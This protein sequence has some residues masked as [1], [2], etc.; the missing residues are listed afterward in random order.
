[1]RRTVYKLGQVSYNTIIM[2]LKQIR[3]NKEIKLYEIIMTQD[4]STEVYK[5]YR[6][7][8]NLKEAKAYMYTY[9]MELV[10]TREIDTKSCYVPSEILEQAKEELVERTLSEI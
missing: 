4:L 5:V 3:R 10:R 2:K 9:G 1:M 6:Y 8:K 7:F